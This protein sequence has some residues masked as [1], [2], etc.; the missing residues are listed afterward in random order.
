MEK[1]RQAYRCT[2]A[3]KLEELVELGG[4]ASRARTLAAKFVEEM[5]QKTISIGLLIRATIRDL[6]KMVVNRGNAAFIRGS[7]VY[8]RA[9]CS[10][11]SARRMPDVQ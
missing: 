9:I 2:I 6:T 4:V 8:R 10:P 7:A 5:R 1:G 3:A 11:Q